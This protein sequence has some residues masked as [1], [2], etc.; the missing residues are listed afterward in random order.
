MQGSVRGGVG[1]CVFKTG[2]SFAAVSKLAALPLVTATQGD[3]QCQCHLGATVPLWVSLL[4]S[5]HRLP[6]S[7]TTM[8]VIAHSFFDGLPFLRAPAAPLCAVPVVSPACVPDGGWSH[9]SV[10]QRGRY[11]AFA[12]LLFA[13]TRNRRCGWCSP[14]AALKAGVRR[15]AACSLQPLA[16]CCCP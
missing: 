3:C 5:P 12:A 1:A 10:R 13:A 8:A 16:S 9:A 7:A 4:A 11:E 2:S 6:C 15:S 14:V